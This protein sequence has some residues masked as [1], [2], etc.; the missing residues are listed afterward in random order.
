MARLGRKWFREAARQPLTRLDAMQR[1]AH[2]QRKGNAYS[3]ER[4]RVDTSEETL[5]AESARRVRYSQGGIQER[6]RHAA[7]K[8]G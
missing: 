2:E 3:H 6:L 8:K 5:T 7:K 1:A 4:R